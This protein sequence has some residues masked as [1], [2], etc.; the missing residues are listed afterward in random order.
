MSYSSWFS[1]AA[2]AMPRGMRAERVRQRHTARHASCLPYLRECPHKPGALRYAQREDIAAAILPD[3]MRCPRV[4]LATHE[5]LRL[6]LARPS[7]MPW[8]D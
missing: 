1:S 2:I 5:F 7:I 4:L 3:V 6:S 8:R